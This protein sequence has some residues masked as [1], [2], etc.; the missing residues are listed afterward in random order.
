MLVFREN[1]VKVVQAAHERMPW[2]IIILEGV[3][4]IER[5]KELV[6]QGASQ[7]MNSR[8]IPKADGLSRAVDIAPCPEGQPSWAWPLYHI[9]ADHMKEAA[10]ELGQVIE[11]GGDWQNFKD[12]PHWQL[13][14]KLYP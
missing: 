5:Q 7:T 2:D 9:L 14:Y 12:G 4:T 3:R 11:W 8:H 13:P 10:Q 1:L 6:A